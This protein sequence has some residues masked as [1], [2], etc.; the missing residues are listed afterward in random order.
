VFGELSGGPNDGTFEVIGCFDDWGTS[1]RS[2][3]G[4]GTDQAAK[5]GAMLT[6]SVRC[7]GCGGCGAKHDGPVFWPVY[8]CV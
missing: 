6:V 5:F 8:T 4:S 3:A 7:C 2:R 1:Y